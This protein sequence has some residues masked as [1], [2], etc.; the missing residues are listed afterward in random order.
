MRKG[1]ILLLLLISFSCKHPKKSKVNPKDNLKTVL[2]SIVDLKGEP[3]SLNEFQGKKVLINY[4]AT[5]CAPC[6]EEMPSL[7][8]LQHKMIPENYAFLLISDEETSEITEFKS[9]M[10]YEFVFLKSKKSLNSKGIYALPTTFIYNEKGKEIEKIV[11]VVSWN[12]SEM[13]DKLKRI[14]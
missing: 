2:A 11:G 6:K 4:W 10:N 1:L 3:V 14:Q 8:E 7:L 13:I 12:S 5:W 9:K